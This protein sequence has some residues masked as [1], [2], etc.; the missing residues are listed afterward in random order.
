[1]RRVALIYNPQSGQHSAQRDKAIH[2]AL[3]LLRDA[4]I[5][6]EALETDAPGSAKTLAKLAMRNGYDTILACAATAPRTKSSSASSEP[7]W[8][9]A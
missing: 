2:R 5:D 1:L 8:L 7:T 9:S 3:A 6:A 4:G